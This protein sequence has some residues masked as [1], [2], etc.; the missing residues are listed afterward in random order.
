MEPDWEIC[1]RDVKMFQCFRE[2]IACSENI[3]YG[4]TTASSWR[5]NKKEGWVFRY[6]VHQPG[7]VQLIRRRSLPCAATRAVIDRNADPPPFMDAIRARIYSQNLHR[8]P[9]WLVQLVAFLPQFHSF[10][11][12]LGE[13]RAPSFRTRKSLFGS[14]PIHAR[15]V[16]SPPE[17]GSSPPPVHPPLSA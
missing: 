15:K 11:R 6:S 17:P 12:S 2:F 10:A 13:T 3:N 5:R 1:S 16:S 4:D 9:P 14:Q 8:D 7:S